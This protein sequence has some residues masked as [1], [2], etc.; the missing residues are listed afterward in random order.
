[1]P[2]DTLTAADWTKA[3]LC[4]HFAMADLSLLTLLA[5]VTA[6]NAGPR[7]RAGCAVARGGRGCV[8]CRGRP[9]GSFCWGDRTAA[10]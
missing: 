7:G 1:M 9:D 3:A 4:R 5:Q 6:A 10:G 2:T 8:G